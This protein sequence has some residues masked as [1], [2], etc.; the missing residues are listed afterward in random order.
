MREGCL[1]LPLA[2]SHR[3][4]R[5]R[6]RKYERQFRALLAIAW[7]CAGVTAPQLLRWAIY[8]IRGHPLHDP[9]R[10][11]RPN[12][13][14]ALSQFQE[15]FRLSATI[16]CALVELLLLP[17]LAVS[18]SRQ[19]EG[20]LCASFRAGRGGHFQKSLKS[21]QRIASLL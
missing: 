13:W 8:Y 21:S 11:A 6:H 14:N 2:G 16:G 5:F 20:A 3:V 9:S 19:D 4:A 7:Q 10:A 1:C 17:R 12:H 15:S 18:G